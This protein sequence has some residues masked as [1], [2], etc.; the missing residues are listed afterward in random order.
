MKL[1]NRREQMSE[2]PQTVEELDSFVAQIVAKFKLPDNEDTYETIA[3]LILHA[4]ASV[5]SAPM[6]FF[7]SSV[8]KS[9]ANKAAYIKCQEFDQKRRAARKAQEPQAEEQADTLKVTAD[10]GPV[11][12]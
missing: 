5:S 7:A 8:K 9:L 10:V 2:L 4:P 6:S 1:F 11:S 12:Q 3:T